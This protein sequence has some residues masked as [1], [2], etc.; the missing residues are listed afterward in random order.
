MPRTCTVCRH[1]ERAEI[2]RELVARAPF[3]NI[4]ARSGLA[5]SSLVRHFDDHLPA[6]LAKAE[7]ARQAA[8]ATDLLK[9]VKI[10]RGKAYALLL[11]AEREGDY[12]TAL[13]GVREARGCLE[14]LAE[15]VGE[16]DR[17]PQ[18][19]ILISSEWL[20][21]RACLLQALAPYPD[22]R[23][24]VATRLLALEDGNGSPR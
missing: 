24:A 15:L 21:V 13:A 2:D 16:L 4:A 9:E 23:A 8:D 17:K 14:L 20:A 18:M 11:A 1:P 5:T 7:D 10:L 3:R 19:N 12:R 22:A 6:E